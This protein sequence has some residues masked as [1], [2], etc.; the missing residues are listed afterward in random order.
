MQV[1]VTNRIFSRPYTA[2][3][4]RVKKD[5]RPGKQAFAK[6]QKLEGCWAGRNLC[7]LVFF[8]RW[9]NSKALG[10]GETRG[11]RIVAPRCI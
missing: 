8:L 2:P 7:D 4:K 1:V 6:V 11:L 10:L 5:W 9:E 3:A